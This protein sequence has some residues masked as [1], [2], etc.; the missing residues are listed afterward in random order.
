M[1]TLWATKNVPLLLYNN[2]GKCRPIFIIII[3]IYF[4][5]YKKQIKIFTKGKKP[6]YPT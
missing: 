1:K 3:I 2:F 4:A 6:E 5:Q